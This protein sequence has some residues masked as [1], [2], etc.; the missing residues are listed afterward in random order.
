MQEQTSDPRYPIG[1]FIE[2]PFAEETKQRWLSD[3][4]YLPG[5]L[6]HSIQNLDET[7]LNTPYR[8]GGWTVKEVVHHVADS[9][10]NSYIRFKLGLTEI[11]P[12]IKPYDEGAWAKLADSQTLPINISLTLLHALHLRWSAVLVNMTEQ[13][14]QR[15]VVHPERKLP[16]SLWSMLGLYAWHGKHH[17]AH[18]TTLKRN[19]N[20]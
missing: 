16:I 5:L 15:T 12:V 14:F 10:I 11:N 8:E 20:W 2:S 4:R 18:I 19:K 9:H 13:E 6:E 3:I 1:H 7:Q 17:V